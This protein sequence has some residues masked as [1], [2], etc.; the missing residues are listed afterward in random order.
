MKSLGNQFP[1]NG[2]TCVCLASYTVLSR[3][4]SYWV[5]RPS[6][7]PEVVR[8]GN[9]EPVNVQARE[10]VVLAESQVHC[11]AVPWT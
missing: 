5:S 7:W 11:L 10:P 6:D 2:G 8:M 3:V 1:D 9:V 4:V